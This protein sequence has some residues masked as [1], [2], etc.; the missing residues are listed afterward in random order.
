MTIGKVK[1]TYLTNLLIYLYISHG[2]SWP[3]TDIFIYF[4]RSYTDS[5]LL[6]NDS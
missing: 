3:S 1:E 6:I 4:L 2:Y 5:Y